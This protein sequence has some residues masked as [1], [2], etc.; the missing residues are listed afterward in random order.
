[1][2]GEKEVVSGAP[3][4]HAG[5]WVRLKYRARE[6]EANAGSMEEINDYILRQTMI[7]TRP[8]YLIVESI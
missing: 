8:I 7:I 3:W 5:F 1:V 2:G 6:D 4:F